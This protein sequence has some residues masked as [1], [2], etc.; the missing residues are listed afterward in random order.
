MEQTAE[1]LS[2]MRIAHR[3]TG[4]QRHPG[5]I[6]MC[7]WVQCGMGERLAWAEQVRHRVRMLLGICAAKGVLHLEFKPAYSVGGLLVRHLDEL[8]REAEQKAV[9]D[10]TERSL[11]T[12]VPAP[13]DSL[14][15]VECAAAR[16]W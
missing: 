11:P 5:I 8:E 6:D 10:Q 16:V 14:E 1:G 15:A 13:R 3:I 12:L 9:F 4:L 2:E 7:G